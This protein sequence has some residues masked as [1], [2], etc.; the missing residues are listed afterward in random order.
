[1]KHNGLVENG[2]VL[3]RDKLHKHVPWPILEFHRGP[4]LSKWRSEIVV[5]LQQ[6]ANIEKQEQTD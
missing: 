2:R 6:E 4:M 1:M 5:I 3:K